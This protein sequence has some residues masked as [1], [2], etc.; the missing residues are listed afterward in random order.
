MLKYFITCSLLFYNLTVTAQNYRPIQWN[1]PHFFS[2]PYF[3]RAINIDSSDFNGADSLYYNFFTIDENHPDSNNCVNV[4]G[5]S[6]IGQRIVVRSDSLVIF[7][8]YD[9]DSLYVHPLASVGSSWTFY[10][11]AGSNNINATVTGI[12]PININGIPDSIKTIVLSNG[13]KIILSRDHGFYKLFPFRDFPSD[14]NSYILNDQLQLT[15]GNV[16]DFDIGDTLQYRFWWCGPNFFGCNV[17]ENYKTIV[18][19]GKYFSTGS[20]TVFYDIWEQIVI[21]SL[22]YDSTGTVIRLNTTIT[23]TNYIS[24]Y[25]NLNNPL[26]NAMPEETDTTKNNLFV[27]F[28]SFDDAANKYQMNFDYCG[29]V[30]AGTFSGDYLKNFTLECYLFPFENTVEQRFYGIGLGNTSN[31]HSECNACGGTSYFYNLRSYHKSNSSC[32]TIQIFNSIN[33]LTNADYSNIRI[34]PNPISSDGY[35]FVEKNDN[36]KDLFEIIDISGKIIFSK[37][38]FEKISVINADEIA[39]GFYI[40]RLS[41]SD[42]SI[43]TGK[44]IR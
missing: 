26:F 27:V 32:G 13:S 34:Y 44:I 40:Y 5:P 41:Y 31:Y 30:V 9:N 3:I 43:L 33:E 11:P 14:T 6:W 25:D 20:D 28:E 42:N 8:N 22:V 7:L 12:N 16:F 29:K 15:N 10:H 2:G 37:Q 21:N 4:F 35:F 24:F 18:V 17:P 36:Q 19:I 38:L 23:D 39:K 1:T